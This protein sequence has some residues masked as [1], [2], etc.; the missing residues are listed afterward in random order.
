MAF[1]I[2]LADGLIIERNISCYPNAGIVKPK[3]RLRNR[4]FPVCITKFHR[5]VVG[6]RVIAKIQ[7]DVCDIPPRATALCIS[8]RSPDA[9]N[10]RSRGRKFFQIV[11]WEA[12]NVG[13]IGDN[14]DFPP[15]TGAGSRALHW[16]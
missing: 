10:L 3:F 2:Q 7:L 11:Y 5:S 16:L 15:H 9:V 14:F 13:V 8:E 4:Q 1:Q 12:C 6:Y